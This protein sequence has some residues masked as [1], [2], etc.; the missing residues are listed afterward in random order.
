MVVRTDYKEIPP[1]V[2]YSL[3]PFGVSLAG[4]L[5]PLCA[6]GEEHSAT[7]EAVVDRR[8]AA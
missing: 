8:E 1:R 3:T 5:V 6:W 2:D 4:S 7:I